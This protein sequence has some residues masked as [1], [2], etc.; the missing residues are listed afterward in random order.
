MFH[1]NLKFNF[2]TS[3]LLIIAFVCLI[4]SFI[5]NLFGVSF[6]KEPFKFF[7]F[8]LISVVTVLG[9]FWGRDNK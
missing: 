1:F 7:V 3:R 5:V 9:Y 4:A 8:I 2:S 6:E